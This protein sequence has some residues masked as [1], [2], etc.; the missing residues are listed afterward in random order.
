[1][2]NHPYD[3][4]GVFTGCWLPQTKASEKLLRV[5]YSSVKHLPFHWSTPPYPRQA[6]GLSV[7]MSCDGGITWEKSAQNP[8]LLGEP[9]DL[10]VTGFRDP[11]VFELRSVSNKTDKN[12]TASYG[13]ISGGIE[14]SGPNAFLYKVDHHNP[15]NW[16][17][18]GP[19]V[20]V[21]L[22]FQPSSKWSGN[23]GV[24]WECVNFV[25]LDAGSES[26]HFLILGAEGDVDRGH[27]RHERYNSDV[28]SRTIR[29]Q[30]W[31]SG[32]LTA[33]TGG[34]EFRHQHGGYFDHGPYYAANSFQDPVTKRCIVYGWIPEEDISVE[35]AKAK[36]WNGS[37]ALPREIFLLKIGNVETSM[38]LSEVYPFETKSEA[39]GSTTIFTLGIRP[40]GYETPATA[41]FD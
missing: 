34:M 5:A 20:N 18:I 29:A 7:A 33:T 13:L 14:G 10:C 30:L 31:M 8:V 19:L 25:T 12:T 40:I 27:L 11:F 28:P 36:G 3:C 22:R 15:E 2:L 41:I 24:N 26:R 32:E 4:E 21:P 1:M 16:E 39:D 9:A 35:A 6:A 17:Y 37:L 38:D 23:Y